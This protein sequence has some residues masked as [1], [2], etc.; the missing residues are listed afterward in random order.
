[1]EYLPY[2]QDIKYVGTLLEGK[3]YHELQKGLLPLLLGNLPKVTRVDIRNLFKSRHLEGERETE[4]DC[5]TAFIDVPCGST[6]IIRGFSD[7]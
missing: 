3:E 2:T 7:S 5:F 4:I 6:H 1:M